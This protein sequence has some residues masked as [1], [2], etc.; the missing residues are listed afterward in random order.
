MKLR[1]ALQN[2]AKVIAEEAERNP[3]FEHRL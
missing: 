2:F 1:T 3:Q